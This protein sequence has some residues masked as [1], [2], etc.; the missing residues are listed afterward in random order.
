MDTFIRLRKIMG[1]DSPILGRIEFW[2][3]NLNKYEK[4][5]NIKDED[6]DKLVND[7]E[8]FKNVLARNLKL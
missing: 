1:D 3:S 4:E 7:V 6:A 8:N 2:L 5:D